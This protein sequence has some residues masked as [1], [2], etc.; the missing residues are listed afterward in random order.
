M[1]SVKTVNMHEAKTQLSRLISDFVSMG[2][3]V[4][5]ANAGKPVA[6]LVEYKPQPVNRIGFMAK[7]IGALPSADSFNRMDEA[8]IAEMFGGIA[9]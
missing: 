1:H 3:E 4:I 9:E 8:L 2:T 5:V 7:D 6:K